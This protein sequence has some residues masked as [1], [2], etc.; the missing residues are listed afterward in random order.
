MGSTTESAHL[1]SREH[2]GQMDPS[3]HTRKAD[4]AEIKQLLRTFGVTQSVASDL[5]RVGPIIENHIDHLLDDFYDNVLSDSN[6]SQVFKKSSGSHLRAKAMQRSH[7]LDWVFAAKFDA[8][9]LARCKRIGRIH[10]EH[11]VLP[12]YYL[13]GYQFVSQAVKDLIFSACDDPKQA[14][15]LAQSVE[16]AIFLDINLAISIYCTE[17]S[18]G[19]RRRSQYDQLTDILNRRGITEKL[20]AMVSST[21]SSHNC[22]HYSSYHSYS[23]SSFSQPR[24][25]SIIKISCYVRAFEQGGHKYK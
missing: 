15:R 11:N 10:Q 3:T 2:R 23:T 6:M 20:N 1:L 24:I 4:E 18:A 7:W 16:K 13:F 19:W 9:Y 5:K 14:Q 21:H 12:V 25:Q 8:H 22:C 17:V